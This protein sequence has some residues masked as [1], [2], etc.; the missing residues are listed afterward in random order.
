MKALN[1]QALRIRLFGNEKGIIRYFCR[2]EQEY[3]LITKEMYDQEKDLQFTGRTYLESKTSEG[4]E[5]WMT[6]ISV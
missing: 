4:Q 6:I 5:R 1:K 2:T 3:F